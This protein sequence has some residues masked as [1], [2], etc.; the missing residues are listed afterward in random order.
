LFSAWQLWASY[1]L[2]EK[3]LATNG[4]NY[5]KIFFIREDLCNSWRKFFFLKD[6]AV[7]GET[8]NRSRLVRQFI[9][10]FP[11]GNQMR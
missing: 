7:A 11:D 5:H 10:F 2:Q 3:E 9:F 8:F 4:T 6:I 1:T